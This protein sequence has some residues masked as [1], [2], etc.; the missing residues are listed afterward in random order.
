MG[1]DVE[2][3]FSRAF[4]WIYS[5]FCES[6]SLEMKAQ[7]LLVLASLALSATASPLASKI[8]MLKQAFLVCDAD[9]DGL[10]TVDEIASHFESVAR[11]TVP[12]QWTPTMVD[13]Y[14]TGY[15]GQLRKMLP[16]HDLNG[17][18]KF[19][20]AEFSGYMD[21]SRLDDPSSLRAIIQQ[22]KSPKII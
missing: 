10:L 2:S 9:G 11:Q 18:G 6:K 4:S 19:D 13:K 8:R 21:A 15:L 22:K 16:P 17:D 14:V 3:D 7:M 20:F 12:R 1:K 5:S